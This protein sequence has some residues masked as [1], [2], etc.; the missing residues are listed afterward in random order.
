MTLEAAADSVERAPSGRPLAAGLVMALYA[1]LALAPGIAQAGH[2]ATFYPSFY[3]QEIRIET[4]DPAAAA[5]GWTKARIHAYAGD[6]LFSGSAVPADASAVGSLHSYLVLTFDATVGRYAVD[7]SDTQSRCSAASQIARGLAPGNPGFVRHPYPITPYHADYLEQFDLAQRAREAYLAPS[8]RSAAVTLKVRARGRL[9]EG[10]LPDGLK[11]DSSGWDATLQ[12]IDIGEFADVRG[13][14]WPG[15]WIGPPWVKLGWFQTY[16]LFGE[17]PAKGRVRTLADAT[18]HRLVTG[19]YQ[20]PTERIN[21]ERSLV[22]GLVASCER[23]VLGYTLGREYFDGDYSN[24]VE[25]VGFDSQTGLTSP[26]FARTVKLKDFPWNGWLRLGLATRPTAA[27]NP[28]AGFSDRFGRLLWQAVG[29]PA[30]LPDPH[31]GSWMANRGSIEA[32]GASSTIP[33]PR[34]ALRPQSG[35]GLLQRVGAGKSAKQRLRFSLVASAFHDGTT[36][37]VADIVYPYLFAFRWGA[38]DPGHGDAFDPAVAASTALMRQWLAGFKVVGDKTLTRNFGDDLKFTYR[39]PVVDV[40]LNH[41][42]SDPW[43]AAAVA[44]PW[45]TLPWE[46]IVLMEEAVERGLAAF[47]QS[48][49]QRRGIPWLDL[50]RDRTVGDRL[51]ALVDEFRRASYRPAALRGLVT[52]AEARERWE[53]LDKFHSEHGHFLVTNGPYRLD[54]GSEGTAVLQVFRDPSYPQGVGS[55]DDYAIPLRAFPTSIEHRAD[56][57]EIAADVER[58][59]RFQ[60]SYEIERAAFVPGSGHDERDHPPVC[61]YVIIGPGGDAVRTGSVTAGKDARFAVDLKHLTEPGLYTVAVAMLVGGNSVNPEIK[62]IVQRVGAPAARS[63]RRAQRPV[64]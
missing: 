56:R 25:N 23:V 21:L 55:F 32:G 54:S 52:P 60:R 29:D 38:K 59:S 62:I 48:E 31:G 46:L 10:L 7:R 16:R 5:S 34:D 19:Q 40:Y 64:S 20:T 24:G 11:A 28:V 12:E 47:S 8:A 26:I 18:Y 2:E 50:V 63:G 45:S 30:L 44:P 42:S 1:A 43:E 53:A 22:S 61:R 15:G 57:L 58:L 6:D 35:T 4:L 49:A 17:H 33:I 51:A 36:T 9:A 39:V 3:P 13:T 41:R 37:G 14:A 27:W